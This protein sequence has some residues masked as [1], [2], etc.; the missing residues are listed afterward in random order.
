MRIKSPNAV[1]PIV[2]GLVIFTCLMWLLDRP[3]P[4]ST[5]Q[6]ASQAT[7]EQPV[8]KVFE[9]IKV[10]K[11]MPQSQLFPTMFFISTSL[12]RGCDFCHV[13]KNGELDSADDDKPE[14]ATARQMM[15]MVLEIR[16]RY[17][18]GNTDLSCYT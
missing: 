14:K 9:N 5:A 17:I 10:L 11:G 3:L 7:A 4:H 16:R 1:K 18:P 15:T 8:E 6:A 12:G 13:I 2:P